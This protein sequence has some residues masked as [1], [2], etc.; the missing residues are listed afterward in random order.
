MTE[1]AQFENEEKAF[2]E[3]EELVSTGNYRSFTLRVEILKPNRF[4]TAC[5]SFDHREVKESEMRVLDYPQVM[6]ASFS[7]GV[8]AWLDLALRL[9]NGELEIDGVKIPANLSYS[10]AE[11]ELHLGRGGDQP[12][13]TFWFSQSGNDQLYL[14]KPLVAPGLP[15]FANLADA[16][17]RFVHQVAVAHNQTPYERTFVI[18]LPYASQVG[19]AEWLPGELRI[20]LVEDKLPGHQLDVFFWE[21]NRVIHAQSILELSRQNVVPVPFGTTIIAGH[22][23]TPEGTIAQSF[24]LHSPYSFLGKATSALSIEQLVKADIVAGENDIREMKTFFNPD[25]NPAMRDRVLHSAIAFAN[26]SGGNIYIGVEDE[27]KLSGNAKL[28]KAMKKPTPQENARDLSA[29]MRKCI[30]ENTRPVIDI[31]SDE[32]KIG[33]EWVVR[34]RIEKSARMITTHMNDVFIRSGASNRRPSAD[35]LEARTPGHGIPLSAIQF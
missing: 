28:I 26:S 34:L 4:V 10:N 16:S 31:S 33:S 27:G 7:D 18:S 25:E 12:R 32:V 22:L 11:D 8:D 9:M 23:L 20:Q 1:Q 14:N 3:I 2:N 30:V 29:K 35:W 5:M 15:P 21:T 24:V 13:K 6:M 17:A 19:L